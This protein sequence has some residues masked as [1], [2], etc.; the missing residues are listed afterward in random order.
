VFLTSRSFTIPGGA[1]I[2]GLGGERGVARSCPAIPGVAKA[3][4]AD[5]H[6]RPSRGFRDRRLWGNGRG[7]PDE[8]AAAAEGI[9]RPD[10]ANH[11]VE[12]GS[13]GQID[14]AADAS[15]II[16]GERAT[17]EKPPCAPIADTK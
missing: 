12:L 11:D 2:G 6:H 4:E 8:A 17:A 10:A 9:R 15:A 5:Q 14:L 13:L 7:I 1:S 16:P 3:G